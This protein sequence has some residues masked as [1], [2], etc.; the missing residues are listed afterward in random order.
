MADYA[1]GCL[2]DKALYWYEGLDLDVQQD[3]SKLKPAILISFPWETPD[4][5]TP[6]PVT[7]RSRIKAVGRDGAF[8]GYVAPLV[9]DDDT[10]PMVKKPEEALVLDIPRAWNNTQQTARIR[11]AV[12]NESYSFLGLEPRP[13]S[14][15]DLRA[16]NAGPEGE[17]RA[18]ANT[19]KA[20]SSKVWKIKKFDDSTEE[21]YAEWIDDTGAKISLHPFTNS[22]PTKW[23]FMRTTPLNTDMFVKLILERF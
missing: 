14:Y 5:E 3:W 6:A 7:S 2:S 8:I 17:G 16:C 11:L 22:I 19:G 10:R 20:A 13:G 21:L 23:I 12:P 18:Q 1:Y 15:W 4:P 9:R